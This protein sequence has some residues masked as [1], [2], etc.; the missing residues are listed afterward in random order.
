[1][2]SYSSVLVSGGAGFIGSHLV[3]ALVKR[4]MRVA[5]LDDLSSGRLENISGHLKGGGVRFVEGDVR[6][7]EDVYEAVEGAEAVFHLAA[8]TSVP[9]SVLH[10]DVTFGVN[11]EGTRNVLDACVEKGVERFIFVSSCAVYGE[12]LDLPVGEVHPLCPVSPYAESKLKAEQL[13][14]V[15]G[16][17]FGLKTTVFRPFNVYGPRQRCDGYA[18][19]IASFVERLRSGL[20]PVIYG[21]GC[22]T[23]DFVYVGDLV[24]A[25]VSALG[26][27]AAVGEVFNVGSGV[28]VSVNELADLLAGLF[29]FNGVEPVYADEREGDIKHIYA[30]IKAARQHLGFEPRVS[31]KDG[32]KEIVNGG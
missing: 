27:E 19:V 5:V 7:R 14:R 1:M 16:E 21:D 30:D 28:P 11:V 17:R 12:P 25:F 4:G 8:V 13:C 31:L 23:R 20:P 10:P 9:F 18:G 2:F 15:Y 6:R 24:E 22:Q 32:L 3:D 26:C 29:G